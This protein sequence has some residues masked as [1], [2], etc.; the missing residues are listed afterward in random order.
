MKL[1]VTG[2]AGLL[3]NNIVNQ[4][5]DRCDITGVDLIDLEISG[6]YYECFSLF[7]TERL[8]R[9]IME[10]KPDA[11]IHTAAAVNVDACE[12]NPSWAYELNDKMTMQLAEICQGLNIP[13]VFIS[14]DAVFDGT[15]PKLYEET[16]VA[17][18]LNVYGKTKLA[19]EKH[20]LKY[21]QNLVFRTNIY[22]LNIQD[23][24]SF[25]E[26]VVSSLKANKELNMF[27]DIKFSPILVNDLAEII[28]IALNHKLAGVYH[29]CATGSVSKYTF[30]LMLQEAFQLGGKIN[31]TD[32]STMQFKAKRSKN[33]GMSNRKI[34]DT[35]NIHIRTPE[36]SVLEFKRLYYENRRI[37]KC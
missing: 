24:E 23:K 14:S 2:I 36:E 11:V 21:K 9:H 19:G 37:E 8:R 16:D 32:S 5:I 6:I 27:E 10:V 17:A 15:N 4:L 18:P 1:Y 28:Y 35:L 22:G 20:V 13:M 34:C 31:K 25:G 29:V 33:M 30:G 26:W 12:S 7:E 3:G